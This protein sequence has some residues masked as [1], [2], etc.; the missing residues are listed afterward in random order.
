MVVTVVSMCGQPRPIDA[1]YVTPI[2][3]V[4][5]NLKSVGSEFLKRWNTTFGSVVEEHEAK[6][7]PSS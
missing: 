4:K 1:L 7:V 5:K 2:L 3:L 6:T